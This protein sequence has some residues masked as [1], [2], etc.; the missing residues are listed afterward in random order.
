VIR[1]LKT[2]NNC[3][4]THPHCNPLTSPNPVRSLRTAPMHSHVKPHS[5]RQ[6]MRQIRRLSLNYQQQRNHKWR[7]A[8]AASTHTH[9][10]MGASHRPQAPKYILAGAP[11]TPRATQCAAQSDGYKRPR[12]AT[13]PKGSHPSTSALS[14][15]VR[16]QSPRLFL[17]STAESKD[18]VG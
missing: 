12:T 11:R 6:R 16:P 8:A 10:C 17:M 1:P 13:S 2:R 18:G 7:T 9:A 15:Y 3:C 14:S 5:E 4:I